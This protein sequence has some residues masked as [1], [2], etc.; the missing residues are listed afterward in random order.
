MSAHSCLRRWIRSLRPAPMPRV[1]LLGGTKRGGGQLAA[2][3][4]PLP[5]GRSWRRWWGR[6]PAGGLLHHDLWGWGQPSS[7]GQGSPST[8]PPRPAARTVA[9]EGG[10]VVVLKE[11]PRGRPAPALP[12]LLPPLGVGGALVWERGPRALPR[13]GAGEAPDGTPGKSELDPS[14]TE[15]AHP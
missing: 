9:G 14:S 15:R 12:V 7:S 2:I 3:G 8:S 6:G 11:A 5:T 4:T 13:P 1:F 10:M